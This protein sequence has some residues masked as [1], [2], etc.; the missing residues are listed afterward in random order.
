MHCHGRLYLLIAAAS[1]AWAGAAFATQEYSVVMNGASEIIDAHGVCANV[2]NNEEQHV[3]VPVKTSPEWAAFRQNKPPD[4]LLDNCPT[5][6]PPCGGVRI[7]GHCW[8]LLS[9]DTNLAH[10]GKSCE[11]L[12][13]SHGGYNEATRTYAGS[14]G[15]DAN[16]T[17][18]MNALGV[19]GSATAQNCTP[20]DI[21]PLRTAIGCNFSTVPI[22]IIGGLL[23]LPPKR[24]TAPQTI[25]GG[26]TLLYGR[27]CACNE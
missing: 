23:R 24:C 12:C 10:V 17:A 21:D 15:T 2:A 22:P 8:Y 26:I 7:G 19:S 27:A 9:G 1:L 4:V 14:D 11:W 16:C 18:V 6:P 13:Q 5:P 25:A 20:L 3:F